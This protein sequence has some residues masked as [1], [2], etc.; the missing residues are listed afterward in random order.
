MRILIADDD[1]VSRTKLKSILNG[2]GRCDT[3]PNGESAFSMFEKSHEEGIPYDLI[4]MDILMPD[5]GQGQDAIKNIR[6]WEKKNNVEHPSKILVVSQL[7]DCEN[8]LSSF[9]EGCAWYLIK[10]VS[11]E[12]IQ[13]ALKKLGLIE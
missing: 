5:P 11:P 3:V 6:E 1:Y 8:I 12:D 9:D 13:E 7:K 4:S 2:Y 10:P